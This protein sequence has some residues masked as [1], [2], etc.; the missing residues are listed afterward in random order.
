MEEYTFLLEHFCNLAA[1]LAASLASKALFRD[2]SSCA[3]LLRERM[4]E[5]ER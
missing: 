4:N 3:S 1:N 5:A 2:S